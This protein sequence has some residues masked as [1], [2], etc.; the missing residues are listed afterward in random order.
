MFHYSTALAT[1]CQVYPSEYAYH[2]TSVTR[3]E[4]AGANCMMY[5]SG[6]KSDVY[7]EQYVHCDGVQRK[8]S[9]SNIGTKPEQYRSS[10]YYV[11][12]AGTNRRQLLF[13]FPSMV[14]LVTITLHYYSDRDSFQGRSHGLPKLKFYAVPDTFDVWDAPLLSYTSVIVAA[15]PPGG[16]PAG[17]RNVSTDIKFN[18]KKVLMEKFS[19]SFHFAVSEVEFFICHSK[20]LF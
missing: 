4:S 10:D 7:T 2:G 1:S 13:I 14:N 18:T 5:S 6:L 17:H 19:S 16:Q 8:L 12:S 11:W 20:H 15:V 9:D 3:T